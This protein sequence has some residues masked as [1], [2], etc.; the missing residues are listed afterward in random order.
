MWT[1]ISNGSL[2]RIII[3]R[4]VESN[5]VTIVALCVPKARIHNFTPLVPLSDHQVCFIESIEFVWERERIFGLHLLEQLGLAWVRCEIDS[6][7]GRL[8]GVV[9]RIA[10]DWLNSDL[11]MVYRELNRTKSGR[12]W[13]YIDSTLRRIKVCIWAKIE[14]ICVKF[15]RASPIIDTTGRLLNFYLWHVQI[16]FSEVIFCPIILVWQAVDIGPRCTENGYRDWY[17]FRLMIW[18][19]IGCPD[20]DFVFA[21]RNYIIRWVWQRRCSDWY[22]TLVAGTRI[23]VCKKEWLLDTAQFRLNLDWPVNERSC[24]W[25]VA[26][27]VDLY[28]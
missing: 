8:L 24:I 1:P 19:S 22:R 6:A 5:A 23:H 11:T 15:L 26:I 13:Q 10:Y 27:T 7:V 25:V 20:I 2:R 16:V 14:C 28:L 9:N 12:V 21:A 3:S 4:H 17:P 18:A